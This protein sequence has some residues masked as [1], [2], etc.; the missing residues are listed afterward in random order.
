MKERDLNRALEIQNQIAAC[1]ERLKYLDA[2]RFNVVVP[3]ALPADLPDL[4]SGPQHTMQ[5]AL[6]SSCLGMDE[7]IVFGAARAAIR[8]TIQAD[9]NTLRSELERMGVEL[10]AKAA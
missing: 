10:E 3:D 7:G 8:N 6:L 5:S 2:V 9:R 1:D 4:R